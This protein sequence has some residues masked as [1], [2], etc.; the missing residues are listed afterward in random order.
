[1]MKD[2]CSQSLITLN[3][4]MMVLNNNRFFR[5]FATMMKS[6]PFL[7]L[8]SMIWLSSCADS[9]PANQDADDLAIVC[10]TGMVADL[11]EA[12][13]DSSATTTFVVPTG[14]DPHT[15]RATPDDVSQ[16]MSANAVVY[17]GLGLEAKFESILSNYGKDPNHHVFSLGQH[18]QD[19][20]LVTIEDEEGHGSEVDPHF[21]F[22]VELWKMAAQGVAKDLASIDPEGAEGYQNRLAAYLLQLEA[23]DAWCKKELQ[24]IDASN[25]VLVTVH[26]AFTYFA[27]HFEFEVRGLQGISPEI[28]AGVYDV[29]NMVN[30]LV[31]N[32]IQAVFV[33]ESLPTKTME[34][35]VSG[36]LSKGHVVSI[37]EPLLADNV[38]V[39]GTEEGTYIGMVKYNVRA[40][41]EGLG[42]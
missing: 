27:R 1:M 14:L 13:S 33:E 24:S 9:T 22:D 12:L 39:A 28:E 10:T 35:V 15:Y 18:L 37:G 20:L 38:G 29:S 21:W 31:E 5:S 30:Y 23:L 4:T 2:R 16:I 7:S 36:C 32:D 8:T 11:V 26:D 42:K 19:S 34:A 3:R 25:R 41:V 6:L 17:S 40:L